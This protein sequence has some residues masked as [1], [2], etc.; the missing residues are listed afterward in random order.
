MIGFEG[1]NIPSQAERIQRL[2][3]DA[4]VLCYYQLLRDADS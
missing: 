3:I 1:K 4:T 2:E